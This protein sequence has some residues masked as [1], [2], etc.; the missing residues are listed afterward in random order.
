MGA[1]AVAHRGHYTTTNQERKQ[2]L[3]MAIES[4][5]LDG[6]REVGQIEVQIRWRSGAITC[7]HVKR[8]LPGE[9]SLKTSTQAVSRIHEMAQRRTYAEIAAALNRAGSRTL[10]RSHW[11]WPAFFAVA[12]GREA[13]ARSRSPPSLR[14][15]SAPRWD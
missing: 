11:C 6:T 15:D 5:Q 12:S 7:D 8:A 4:V 9:G 13:D 10:T 3:R 14:P 2:L 1:G